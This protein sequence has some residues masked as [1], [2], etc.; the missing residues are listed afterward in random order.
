[1]KNTISHSGF[2]G[3]VEIDGDS[4]RI[5]IETPN[6]L[7]DLKNNYWNIDDIG[8][9]VDDFRES[10]NERIAYIEDNGLIIHNDEAFV[11]SIIMGR[12]VFEELKSLIDEVDRERVFEIIKQIV[13][14]G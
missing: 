9:A 5:R 6:F 14:N 7:T 3:I 2:T 13:D 8:V 12:E 1:M 11:T 10:I 4:G